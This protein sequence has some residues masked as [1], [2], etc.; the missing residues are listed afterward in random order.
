MTNKTVKKNSV[1]IEWPTT[2]FTID[3]VQKKYGD[4]IINITLRFRFKKALRAKQI[5]VIG[6]IKPD[7]GRPKLVFAQANPSK[8]LLEVAKMAGVVANEPKTSVTVAEMT[9]GKKQKSVVP[10]TTSTVMA[11][12]AGG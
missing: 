8:E 2:H 7:I 4:A 9:S 10:V 5:V 11:A 12:Q 1:T 6:K 3:D